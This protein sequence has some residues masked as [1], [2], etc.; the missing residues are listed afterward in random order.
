[1]LERGPGSAGRLKGNRAGRK[2]A[3]THAATP[4]EVEIRDLPPR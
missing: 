4:S 1:M 3:H 2:K